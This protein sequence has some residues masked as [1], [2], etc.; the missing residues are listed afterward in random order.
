[1]RAWRSFF[2]RSRFFFREALRP[3]PARLMK[4]V[5]MRMPEAGPLGETFFEASERAM[6]GALLVKRS[7][8]GW[9]E[10]VVTVFTQR[11]LVGIFVG[12]MRNGPSGIEARIYENSHS[13]WLKSY[14]DASKTPS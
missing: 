4:Y 11:L 8:P 5:S 7:L 2:A 10:S 6:T 14:T 9:V 1:M 3:L 13:A 12:G